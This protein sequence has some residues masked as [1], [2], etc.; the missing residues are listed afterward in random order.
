MTD[1]E[2][3]IRDG[4]ANYKAEIAALSLKSQPSGWLFIAVPNRFPEK[5]C[6][7]LTQLH[8]RPGAPFSRRKKFSIGNL[9]PLSCT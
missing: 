9:K 2:K 3:E 7:H 4:V 5:Q 6:V 8:T 1:V